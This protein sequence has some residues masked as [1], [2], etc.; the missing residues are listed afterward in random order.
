[1]VTLQELCAYL[2]QLLDAQS[3]SDYSTNGIHVEGA[4]NIGKIAAA[5]SA[6]LETIQAAV[7]EGVDALIVHHGM[8]WKGDSYAISG[9]KREK[10]RLLLTHEISLIAY[11]L[12]LD[13]HRECGN[14]W[15]AAKEMNWQDLK[16][17]GEVNGKFLG[18]KGHFPKIPVRDFQRLLEKY[19]QHPSHSALGGRQTVETAILVSGGAYKMLTEAAKE[20]ADCFITGNFDEPAWHQAYEEHINFFAMGH[21][22]TEKVGPKALGEHLKVHYDLGYQFIDTPNPF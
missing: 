13:A 19:Y 4:Q 20:G 8:F 18:V 6:S 1:M 17:F 15:K 22:A 5:V 2:D 11:H 7:D 12:P 21:A 14:N 10:L 9:T 3:F 16:P